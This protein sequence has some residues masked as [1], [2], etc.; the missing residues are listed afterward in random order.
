MVNCGSAGRTAIGRK[1]SPEGGMP[2]LGGEMAPDDIWDVIA[3]LRTQ[4]A[5]EKDEGGIK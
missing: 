1:A 5:H 2:R 3:W 4:K